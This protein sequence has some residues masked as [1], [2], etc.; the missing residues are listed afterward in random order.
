LLARAQLTLA[1]SYLQERKY[2]EARRELE[3]ARGMEDLDR[4]RR[5]EAGALIEGIDLLPRLRPEHPRVFF[6]A[7]TWPAV[8]ERALTAERDLFNEMK[9]RVDG[10]RAEE[11]HP[12]DWGTR[13]AEAALVYRVTDDPAALDKA[14][15]M[16]RATAD[17][18]VGRRYG[19][20]HSTHR[21]GYM[22]ALDWMW[23]DLPPAD[24]RALAADTLKYLSDMYEED[25]VRDKLARIPHYY[26]REVYWYGGLALVDAQ[27]RDPDL[28]RALALLGAGFAHSR[29]AIQD[30]LATSGDDGAWQTN[31]GYSLGDLPNSHGWNFMHTWQSALGMDIPPAWANSN[32]SPDYALRQIVRVGPLRDPASTWTAPGVFHFG[33]SR[34]AIRLGHLDKI[35]DHLTQ[36]IHFFGESQPEQAAVASYLRSRIAEQIRAFP[37]AYPFF[38]FLMTDLEQKTPPPVLPEGMPVAR[39]F[40][41]VGQVLMSSGFGPEDT[42]ALFALGGGRRST[43]YTTA[44]CH[45]DA[46]HFTICKQ[47]YLAIDSG[48]QKANPHAQNYYYQTVAHNAVLIRMPGEEFGGIESN[49]GGQNRYHYHAEPLGFESHP[50]YAYAASDATETYHPDKCAQ[51]VRQFIYLPPDHFV[52]FDRVA[53]TQAE[54][55]KKWL[56]HTSTESVVAGKAFRADQDRGRIFC[57]TLYPLD[58]VLEK[59]GGPG[60]EFWAAG[61][62]W[63][64]E[65]EFRYWRYIGMAPGGEVP[66]HAGRWRV[67]VKPGAA[68][69]QDYF[70][71]LIQVADQSVD[72][73]VESSVR[74]TEDRIELT[75]S[76]GA[77]RYT[78]ALNKA[79]AVGG[80][81]RIEEDGEALV[82]R[83][84]TQEIMAQAGLALRDE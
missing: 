40:E 50:L 54:Y 8:R 60:K 30:R 38:R 69:E 33:Y 18:L 64:I 68:R 49:S 17:F 66:E 41:G 55:P 46:T 34:T 23:N 45:F 5:W 42:Y 81:I 79:G 67:E 48:V 82:D 47:G 22:A 16:L 14:K 21:L 15:A 9:A 53:S 10:V 11:I 61:R 25:K 4:Q 7:Q 36:F 29:D 58:A 19:R 57:R 43:T 32:V 24:R 35:Y 75:F 70:L 51:M 71:H 62:N 31:I 20:S 74:E 44:S 84:L 76:V 77:R 27:L 37:G 80:H 26:E 52:V 72:E 28:V 63:P 6:N 78:I 73:M 13:A 12:D 39:H 59:I 2:A 65:E 83:P 3:Q 1:R 56:L